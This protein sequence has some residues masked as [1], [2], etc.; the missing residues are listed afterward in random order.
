MVVLQTTIWYLNKK[1]FAKNV[2]ALD[3]YKHDMVE[4]M[5]ELHVLG[6][7]YN[8]IILLKVIFLY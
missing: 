3:G 6:F 1:S 5:L 2:P 4:G 8:R 7:K